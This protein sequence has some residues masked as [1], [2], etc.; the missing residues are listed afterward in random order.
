[1]GIG[2][3]VTNSSLPLSFILSSS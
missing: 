2:V 1:M 3:K